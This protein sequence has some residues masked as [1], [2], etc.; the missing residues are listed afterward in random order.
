[1]SLRLAGLTPGEPVD[2][3][4]ATTTIF[5][6][7]LPRAAADRQASC[8]WQLA[9]RAVGR[10]F[11]DSLRIQSN[12]TA[13]LEHGFLHVATAYRMTRTSPGHEKPVAEPTPN[14]PL[15]K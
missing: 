1:M 14:H 4:P 13:D 12:G 11:G 10:D 15:A 9:R 8:S 5:R 7:M 2:R 6:P 3:E